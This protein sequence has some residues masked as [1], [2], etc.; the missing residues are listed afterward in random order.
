MLMKYTLFL[1]LP[2]LLYSCRHTNTTEQSTAKS[3]DTVT[4][5]PVVATVT[6]PADF[7]FPASG[8]TLQAFVPPGYF[9]QYEA[10]GDL[11]ED[12]LP[13]AAMVL[14]ETADSTAPRALVVLT[15]QTGTP[16]YKLAD[17]GWNAIG[18]QYTGDGYEIRGTEDLS[19]EGGAVELKLYDPGPSGNLFST[20]RFMDGA[21][22]LTTLEMFYQ[23][24]GGASGRTWN[25]LTGEVKSEEIN[26]TKDPEESTE[27]TSTKE[28]ER[29]LLHDS[30][31]EE[32]AKEQG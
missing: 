7:K 27:A 17:A 16:K 3:F 23:G 2:L 18:P 8:E 6:D 24:A 13:D 9:I 31:P 22:Q 5:A 30:D 26:R 4:A 21:I 12:G 28:P 29:V 32:L 20:Y 15:Q 10:A 14:R 1:G 25:L 11:N 19:I